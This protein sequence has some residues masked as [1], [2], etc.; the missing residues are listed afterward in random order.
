MRCARVGLAASISW[1]VVSMS[2]CG[3][4]GFDAAT[5]GPVLDDAAPAVDDAIPI[6]APGTLACGSSRR[7]IELPALP[8][9]LGLVPISGG[10]VAAWTPTTATGAN[11]KLLGLRLRFAGEDILS[12][13]PL[14]V[15]LPERFTGF[16][17]V[18]DG[19]DRLML[20]TEVSGGALFVPLGADLSFPG[21]WTLQV[22]A[23]LTG[24]GVAEPAAPGGAF[25]AGWTNLDG[26]VQLALL[27]EQGSA[28]GKIL[29]QPTGRALA[30]RAASGR[31]V[32][33][34]TAPAQAGCVVW[35]VDDGFDPLLPDPLL[36][37]PAGSCEQPAITRHDSGINLLMWIADGQARVQL[38]TDTDTVGN[39]LRINAGADAI[40]IS[41][42]PTGFFYAIAAGPEVQPGHIVLDASRIFAL[43][44]VP[45]APGTPI[46]LVPD[47]D[48]AL[49]LTVATTVNEPGLWL[50]RLCEPGTAAR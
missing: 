7:L 35:A 34:W 43:P 2:G 17:L 14:G 38:G 4:L 8:V 25:A 27:D 42:A 18:S 20:S 6:G 49:L 36:H 5:G 50:T 24:H 41:T 12:V 40:E 3:R 13:D 47:G 22:N 48:G 30:I 10:F 29:D 16:G 37:A 33:A 26:E 31:Y 9:G 11:T 21:L 44:N 32:T 28:D 19:A 46:R 45:R 23:V 39:Q 1:V 15:Q